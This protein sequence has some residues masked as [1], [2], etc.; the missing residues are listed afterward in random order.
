[1]G[2]FEDDAP[3]K[4]LVKNVRPRARNKIKLEKINV[5]D[6]VMV[7]YNYDEPTAR[8][9]WYDAIVTDKRCTR[10]IKEI[11]ATVFFG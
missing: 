11:E 1:M 3:V 6:R 7:N 10:T 8:G 9:Y 4:L 2:R 5:G